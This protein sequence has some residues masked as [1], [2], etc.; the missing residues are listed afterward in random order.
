[1]RSSSYCFLMY[2]ATLPHSFPVRSCLYKLNP[3]NCK[4]QSG[5]ESFKNVSDIAM[6]SECVVE[7]SVLLSTLF[8]LIWPMQ[9]D[10]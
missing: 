5:V 10:F 2:K 8:A 1:M 7:I 6:A 9:K 3:S 4:W